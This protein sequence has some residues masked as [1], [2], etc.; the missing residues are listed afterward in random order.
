MMLSLCLRA[1]AQ[2][3]ET[4]D[5]KAAI[6]GSAVDKDNDFLLLRDAS[7]TTGAALKKLTVGDLVY[8][9][10]LF[11][12]VPSGVFTLGK[13]AQSGATTGQVATWNG[14]GWAP[15]NTMVAL[16]SGPVTSSGSVS[17][18]TDGA[19]TLAKLGQ[20]GAA[21]GQLATWNGSAWVPADNAFA[22]TSGP[23]TSTGGVSAIAD[24][25]LTIAK[26]TGLTTA[27]DNARTGAIAYTLQRIPATNICSFPRY[28]NQTAVGATQLTA[29]KQYIAV[30][31]AINIRIAFANSY[32]DANG[33]NDVQVK[34]AVEKSGVFYPVTFN[35]NRM[36]T[37]PLN[38]NI[39]TSDDVPGLT[40]SRGQAYFIRT[41]VE[42]PV[43]GRA[44]GNTVVD[45]SVFAGEGLIAGFDYADSGTITTATNYAFG[46]VVITGQ[47]I[48][49][50]SIKPLLLVGDSIL[51]G[52]NY[53]G[54][55]SYEDGWL[56]SA[57]GGIKGSY[58]SH[59]RLSVGGAKALQVAAGGNRL[60]YY[61]Y[62]R[63][64]NAVCNLGINDARDVVTANYTVEQIKTNLQTIW[65]NLK[66]AGI[67]K[68]WQCTITPDT[69]GTAQEARRLEIN[70]WIRTIPPPLVGIIEC[71]DEM[72]TS[73]DS[74]QWKTG[75]AA[76]D[77]FHPSQAGGVALR[78]LLPR[79]RF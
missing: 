17:A 68:I 37:V 3:V 23:V 11:S 51:D 42:I 41:Y 13:L 63:G 2:S 59:L 26:T 34:C 39:V 60:K 73:R 28:P 32:V 67:E 76:G 43:G 46:P 29:R 18:I 64:G 20:S 74:G 5:Q 30:C 54:T 69:S 61:G 4:V 8:V 10:G 71:A 47:P 7:V 35:G 36:V 77:L 12:S 9:P 14:T 45:N 57:L 48:N 16:T 21:A 66:E 24:G 72:E 33:T 65:N 79:D 38:G 58:Y 55:Y 25:A 1:H 75:Y 49:T 56:V 53:G 62:A 78:K 50:P 27:I 52:P 19:V 40:L 70:A 31:D 6:S 44:Y 15:A 22:L